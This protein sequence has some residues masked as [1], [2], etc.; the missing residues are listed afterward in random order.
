MWSRPISAIKSENYECPE[1]G[2][3]IDR[4]LNASINLKKRVL[5]GEVSSECKTHS[6][7]AVVLTV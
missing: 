4:D 6:K 3:S 5:I 2:L 7:D 1:C